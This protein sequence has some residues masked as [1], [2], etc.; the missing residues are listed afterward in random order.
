V[1]NGNHYPRV[2]FA[3]G[4]AQEGRMEKM[5]R[6]ILKICVGMFAATNFVACIISTELKVLIPLNILVAVVCLCI[7]LFMESKFSG[8]AMDLGISKKDARKLVREY[9]NYYKNVERVSVYEYFDRSLTKD[10]N[11]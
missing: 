6:L 7:F 4:F 2:G 8:L 10:E 3:P 11:R 1:I 9:F 5:D